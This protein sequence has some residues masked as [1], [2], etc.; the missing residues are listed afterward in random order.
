MSK[1][2]SRA[3]TSRR[4]VR[5]PLSP[6]ASARSK[7]Q[8]NASASESD[9][10]DTFEFD[11]DTILTLAPS[12]PGF[13][14]PSNHDA[15]TLDFADVLA[16][17]A[18]G[19]PKVFIRLG[20]RTVLY[21]Q[22]DLRHSLECFGYVCPEAAANIFGQGWLRQDGILLRVTEAGRRAAAHFVSQEGT[23]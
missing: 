15:D 9:T 6:R 14:D 3:P 17:I 12:G 10:A 11:D 5:K 4:G 2:P 19:V 22:G 21:E 16:L 7:Q 23:E 8:P 13:A 1:P 20:E 18:G